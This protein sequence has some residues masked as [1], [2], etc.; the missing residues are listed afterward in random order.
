MLIKPPMPEQEEAP[1]PQ[2]ETGY[3]AETEQDWRKIKDEQIIICGACGGEMA[4]RSRPRFP[5]LLGTFALLLGFILIQFSLVAAI[6]F[7]L[8]GMLMGTQTLKVW[9]CGKCKRAIETD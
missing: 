7:I 4:R 2:T 5:P 8:I 1:Q 3:E 9:Q 6:V